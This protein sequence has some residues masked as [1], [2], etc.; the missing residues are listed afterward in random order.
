MNIPIRVISICEGNSHL[1]IE[2]N[3]NKYKKESSVNSKS[4]LWWL[5]NPRQLIIANSQEMPRSVISASCCSVEPIEKHLRKQ[6][7]V[8]K[9]FLESNW[10]LWTEM[11]D[12]W[13]ICLFW[14]YVCLFSDILRTYQRWNICIL[15]ILC[16]PR[17]QIRFVIRSSVFVICPRNPSFSIFQEPVPPLPLVSVCKAQEMLESQCLLSR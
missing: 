16:K 9:V 6:K 12:G 4:L 15:A 11:V 2:R 5:C 3:R 8:A 1:S 10:S 7:G 17:R 13:M 14:L